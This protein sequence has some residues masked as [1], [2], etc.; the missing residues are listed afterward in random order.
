MD[1]VSEW[2]WIIPLGAPTG[3]YTIFM[4]VF[5][6]YPPNTRD[7][8]V[9]KILYVMMKLKLTKYDPKRLKKSKRPPL[10]EQIEEITVTK[11]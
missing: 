11:D 1:I 4:R 3:K 2:G 10:R 6:H 9:V 8:L 5:P 7:R